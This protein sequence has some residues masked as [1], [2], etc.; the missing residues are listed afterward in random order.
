MWGHLFLPQVRL[1][2]SLGTSRAA[3]NTLITDTELIPSGG[4]CSQTQQAPDSRLRLRPDSR[5]CWFPEI[6]AI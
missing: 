2:V 6:S 3:N 5:P 4:L 1:P